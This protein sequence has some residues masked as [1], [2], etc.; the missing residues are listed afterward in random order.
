LGSIPRSCNLT[1][2]C[3]VK[4]TGFIIEVIGP[5]PAAVAA[6]TIHLQRV[7]AWC[8]RRSSA[9]APTDRTRRDDGVMPVICPTCQMVSK[10]AS[11]IAPAVAGYFAWGCFRYFCCPVRKPQPGPG[12]IMLRRSSSRLSYPPS[13]RQ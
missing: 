2:A 13:A 11:G 9:R 8:R 6:S 1:R 7:C 3:A 5:R 10:D 4:T 12:F